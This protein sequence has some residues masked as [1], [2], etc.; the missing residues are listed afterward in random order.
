MANH[1]KPALAIPRLPARCRE[2]MR[3]PV[4][5]LEENASVASAARLM[6]EHGVG[7][8]VVCSSHGALV[9]V[10]TDRDIAVRVVAAGLDS[11]VTLDRVMSRGV[12]SCTADDA[13]VW[14]ERLMRDRQLTRIVVTDL[15]LR[16]V[17]IISLSDLA[18]Y[19]PAARIGRTLRAVTERKYAPERP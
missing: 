18:Q 5:V 1:E 9:G 13:L 14:A 4:L 12:V 16:P 6:S 11:A 19:E 8:V 7:L 2:V 15:R 3:S 10:L 17:G